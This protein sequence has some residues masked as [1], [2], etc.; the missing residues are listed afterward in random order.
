MSVLRLLLAS[1]LISLAIPAQ[2][3]KGLCEINFTYSQKA[4]LKQAFLIGREM[5]LAYSLPA[6][7]WQESS[8]GL[9]QINLKNPDN[10]AAGPY[11]NLVKNVLKREQ[12]RDTKANRHKVITRLISDFQFATKH[13][14][15]ELRYW[16][17]VHNGDWKKVWGSYF[18][19]YKPDYR[20]AKKIGEKAYLIS[21]CNRI[22][23]SLGFS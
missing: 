21:K 9:Y 14:I 19:G 4:L 3:D 1:L 11:Q 16:I 22:W 2:A 20:Y 6:I 8:A 12:M 18:G 17:K 7:A 15:V 23:F 5:G 13:A 10:P